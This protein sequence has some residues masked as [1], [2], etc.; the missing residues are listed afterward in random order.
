MSQVTTGL[1]RLV[2]NPRIYMMIQNLLGGPRARRVLVDELMR[3]PP[4][5]R[6]LDLGCGTADILHSIGGIV[7]GYVGIDANPRHIRAA[8][9]THRGRGEFI[10]GDFAEAAGLPPEGFDLVLMIG[11]LHH[12][13]DPQAGEAVRLAGRLMTPNGR[14][15]TIDPCR[16]EPQHPVARFLIGR[17]SGRAVRTEPGYRALARAA[18][19][20][21]ESVVRRDIL[22]VPYTHCIMNCRRRSSAPG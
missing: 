20:Q 11:L 7:G 10:C 8:R 16:T 21:V 14:L 18:F 12:L 19:D 6:V 4:D 15:F 22:R 2:G 17:D 9:Q 13:S 5:G 3:P 1:Y